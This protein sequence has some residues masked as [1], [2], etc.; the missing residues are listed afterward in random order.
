MTPDYDSG[1][2]AKRRLPIPFERPLDDRRRRRAGDR[3][4]SSAREAVGASPEP[5]D[6]PAGPQPYPFS[7]LIGIGECR[8][9]PSGPIS[10]NHDEALV[11]AYSAGWRSW[12][13]PGSP[14]TLGDA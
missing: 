5:T 14:D 11:E 7:N 2:G 6:P 3:Q 9:L 4:T 12:D 10:E 1:M 8:P 13:E